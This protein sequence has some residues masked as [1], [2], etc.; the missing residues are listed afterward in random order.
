MQGLL[1]IILLF[2]NEFNKLINTGVRMLD[3][4]Y[5]ITLKLH[6]NC[7]FGVSAT[8]CAT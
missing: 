5:D 1:S 4:L 7:I 6:L 2:R 3:S 8:F